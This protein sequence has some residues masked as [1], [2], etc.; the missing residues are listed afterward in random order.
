[1]KTW[2]KIKD[3]LV[4]KLDK[5]F[6][7]D[8]SDRSIEIIELDKFFRFS[9][10]TYGRVELPAG[11]VENG[12]IINQ[13]A[14]AEKL[15]QL[16][17]DAKPRKVSTNKVIVSLPESQVFVQC[18]V[19][20]ATLKSAALVKAIEERVPLFLPFNID[21]TYWDFM[22]KP[23]A[24]KKNKLIMFFGVPKDIANSYVKFCNSIGLEVTSLCLESLSLARVMLRSSP[25]QSL[26]MDI[27][28]R[29]TSLSFFDSNDKINMSINVPIAGDHMTEAV[30]NKL[31]VE[32]QE[33]ES[34]KVK[35]GFKDDSGNNILPIISPLMNDILEETKKAISY[36]EETYNQSLEDVYIIGGSS[37]LP[38][39]KETIKKGL[40]REVQESV[41][42]YNFNL[43]SLT[44]GVKSFPLYANV[45]GLGMLGT[46][47]Q[48]RDI[49]LLKKMPA[50]EINSVDKLGLF[51]LSYLSRANTIRTILNN[52]FVL[53]FLVVLIAFVS[54]IL[55]KQAEN[56]IMSEAS[57][58]TNFFLQ[59]DIIIPQV[60]PLVP[61]DG[62]DPQ[63]GVKLNAN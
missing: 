50:S 37:L 40:N 8:I 15:K 51:N 9:V 53:V 54:F 41:S 25:K 46:S 17:K 23:L 31:K 59:D 34:L 30:E 56:Y 43:N 11:I 20:D 1:M 2:E 47:S 45:I 58:V 4:T 18:F 26:I 32:N 57:T 24:D 36:Y 48:F 27:G 22:E 16:L 14:L 33:A 29:S 42:G 28:A 63:T 49:N 3:T 10:S 12:K 39:I 21:K 5:S 35:F 6:G 7:L 44:G 19:M 13:S 62:L 38:S 61:T 55:F 52:R 60:P